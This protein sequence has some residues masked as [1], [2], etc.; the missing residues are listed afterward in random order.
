MMAPEEGMEI[1]WLSSR[2]YLESK[3]TRGGKQEGKRR[4]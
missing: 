2:G 3:E 4:G 1:Y